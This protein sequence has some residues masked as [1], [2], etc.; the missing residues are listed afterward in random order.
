MLGA[1]EAV[2]GKPPTMA[3]IRSLVGD[4]LRSLADDPNVVRG[5]GGE[6]AGDDVQIVQQQEPIKGRQGI[7]PNVEP[8]P[9]S[10]EF[11]AAMAKTATGPRE[12]KIVIL[13]N[14]KTVPSE[15]SQ[16]G[17]LM[18]PIEDLS[19]VAAAGRETFRNSLINGLKDPL[20]VKEAIGYARALVRRDL[21]QGGR[22]D[23]QRL[24]IPDNDAPGY[25]QLPQFRDVSNF[26]VGLY[27]QQALVPLDFLLSIAG[28]YAKE[29]S[30]N[31]MPKEPYGLDPRT[32]KWIERGYKAGDSGIFTDVPAGGPSRPR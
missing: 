25:L 23:H 9:G 15:D 4:V 32:R 17:F 5:T 20:K 22:F 6:P 10:P 7:A 8:V 26:N 29:N 24:W 14:G 31:Y 1:F 28:E 19:H 27:M 13:P 11:Q 16:T 2:E 18:S 21:A 3:D 12:G 30:S